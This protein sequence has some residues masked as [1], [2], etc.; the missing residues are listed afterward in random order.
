MFNNTKGMIL[1]DVDLIESLKES[2]ETSTAVKAKLI[3][4]EEKQ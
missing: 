4:A 2:K 1:D 3:E